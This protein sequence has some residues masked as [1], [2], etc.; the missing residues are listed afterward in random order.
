MRVD[1]RQPTL[2]IAGAWNPAIFS[3]EWIATKILGKKEND[4]LKFTHV[5]DSAG[6]SIFYFDEIGIHASVDR[7]GIYCN[8]L[9]YTEKA[10]ETCLKI[11][12]LLSHTP[13]T[14]VGVNRMFH[15]ENCDAE[16]IDK[17]QTKENI[18]TFR[19]VI[20]QQLKTSIEFQPRITL[21]F[22]RTLQAGNVTFNFNYH[23]A[24][25]DAASAS[26]QVR[27]AIERCCNDAFSFL[28]EVYGIDEL[29]ECIRHS[30]QS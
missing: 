18:N 17:M 1:L 26:E 20:S 25:I 12:D 22:E 21:N 3:L 24:V 27:G 15:Q 10:E 29:E 14:G 23:H 28:K 11:L 9:E 7:L 30:F 4:T 8:D 5:F 19:K 13:V 2:V 16:I 6:D